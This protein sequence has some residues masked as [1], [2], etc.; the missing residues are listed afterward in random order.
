MTCPGILKAQS[1]KSPK[2]Q[3]K[4]IKKKRRIKKKKSK[5]VLLIN[6]LTIIE[7]K[8]VTEFTAGNTA[9]KHTNP[10]ENQTSGTNLVVK[11]N[12]PIQKTSKQEDSVPTPRTKTKESKT[13][14][15][16]EQKMETRETPRDKIKEKPKEVSSHIIVTL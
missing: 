8:K 1:T 4:R 9:S 7:L 14:V 13:E 2:F 12:E 3:H 15:P 6:V 11:E 16:K 5:K 10:T